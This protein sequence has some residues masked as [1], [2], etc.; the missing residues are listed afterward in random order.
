MGCR[1]IMLEIILQFF[2]QFALWFFLMDTFW[3][4]E[5][6]RN[7]SFSFRQK[8]W[9][10]KLKFYCLIWNKVKKQFIVQKDEWLRIY[11]L[12]HKF[13]EISEFRIWKGKCLELL[14]IWSIFESRKLAILCFWGTFLLQ[15]ECDWFEYKILELIK[16]LDIS[17]I[18]IFW[19]L[20]RWINYSN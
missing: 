6:L 10:E 8:C 20:A 5:N 13:F 11:L 7:F 15:L 17:N 16:Q 14:G 18:I 3:I 19:W 9:L 4:D 2:F 12:L 1:K